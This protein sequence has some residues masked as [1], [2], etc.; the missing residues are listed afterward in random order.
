MSDLHNMS[1]HL[2]YCLP[3]VILGG[4]GHAKVLIDALLMCGATIKGVLDPRLAKGTLVLADVSVIGDDTE[5]ALYDPNT[6]LVVNGVGSLPG[7]IKRRELYNLLFQRNYR[8][9]KVIHQTAIISNFAKLAEGVQVMAGSV[10]QAGTEIGSNTIINTRASI[11]HD[12]VI[13]QHVH[14]APGAVLS[15]E[16]IVEDDVHIGTGASVIQGIHIGAG[17]VIGAG[18]SVGKNV[19]AGATVYPFRTA[20][21]TRLN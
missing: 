1:E 14:I 5:L 17:A 2:N 7:Q 11:D 6:V 16:V 21:K 3:L 20:E 9:T 18:A 8:F 15:G 12:C 13:G 10:I 4:G 19:A